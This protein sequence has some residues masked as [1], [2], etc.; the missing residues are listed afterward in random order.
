MAELTFVQMIQGVLEDVHPGH[1]EIL[2]YQSN[3]EG[4]LESYLR[5]A[6]KDTMSFN[7]LIHYPEIEI[8]NSYDYKHTIKDL[9]IM[10][11]VSNGFLDEPRGF[12]ATRSNREVANNYVHSHLK[13]RSDPGFFK[14]CIGDTGPFYDLC[15]KIQQ[16]K[17]DEISFKFYLLMLTSF[18]KWESI[19]G[20]PHSYMLG[21]DY[22][23]ISE[24]ND[25]F[26][27]SKKFKDELRKCLSIEADM[28]HEYY[29]VVITPTDALDAVMPSSNQVVNFRDVKYAK[30][31]VIPSGE[32]KKKAVFKTKKFKIDE[33]VY[34]TTEDVR[35]VHPIQETVADRVL[36][37]LEEK[38]TKEYNNIVL[39]KHS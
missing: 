17:T 5:R 32:S 15:N 7:I 22:T 9:Y 14:F 21:N 37:K 24:I 20:G 39:W 1:F 16:S 2:K 27:N 36:P 10:I 34:I 6:P 8:T 25:G 30:K 28:K 31:T 18:L 12:R 33:V 11:S 13:Y 19:E 38:L 4:V 26:S 35:G 3:P 23:P 29:R